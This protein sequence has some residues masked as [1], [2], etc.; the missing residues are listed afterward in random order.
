MDDGKYGTIRVY[1]VDYINIPN[2]QFQN[3]LT[4]LCG[5][6]ASYYS[7]ETTC[8]LQLEQSKLQLPNYHVN[9]T[10]ITVRFNHISR[11]TSL[12]R[13]WDLIMKSL[14]DVDKLKIACVFTRV[15]RSRFL[16][17]SPDSSTSVLYR[18]RMPVTG[19]EPVVNDV[20]HCGNSEQVS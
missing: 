19:A 12:K 8:F 13:S 9:C 17:R 10:L 16:Y 1:L 3:Y 4:L 14:T 18:P 11:V 5:H 7:G 2:L 15:N 20:T 6:I